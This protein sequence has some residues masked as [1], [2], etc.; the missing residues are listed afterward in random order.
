[1]LTIIAN[2]LL[3]L[4]LLI[5]LITYFPLRKLIAQLPS[6]QV[7]RKWFLQAGLVG[8][9]ILGYIGYG[10]V[11][12]KDH[13]G[14]MDLI[15]PV[16]FFFGAA[17]VWMTI[18]L[19]LQT[20]V[21]VRRVTLLEQENITDPLIG[22]YNRRFLNRRLTEEFQKANRYHLPLSILLIDIDHFKRV[23]DT[24][25]HQVG[26]R[27]LRYWGE[28]ILG[29]V[30]ASDLVAR[31]GGEEILVIAPNTFLSAGGALAERI[32]TTVESHELI[33][34]SE[35]DR[36]QAIRI[37]VSIGV[38][39][40]NSKITSIENFLIQADEALYRAKREGRNRVISAEDFSPGQSGE[41]SGGSLPLN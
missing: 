37:T 39:E 20:A 24:F 36:R 35:T 27:V 13:A 41:E 28:L 31:Y 5:L 17:F 18:K 26:D 6:S 34:S 29:I 8:L 9:F 11:T 40:L 15:V 25:G 30:R 23:N 21:D 22:I 19:S 14:Y 12:W 16:V 3:V 4:G 38:A 2:F 7:R 32:R 1:M 10:W 33:L